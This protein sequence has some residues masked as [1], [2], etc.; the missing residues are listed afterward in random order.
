[1][2]TVIGEIDGAD[3]AQA[4]VCS[5]RLFDPAPEQPQIGRPQA[6]DDVPYY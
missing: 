2:L 3:A 5:P 1:V 6:A 4:D